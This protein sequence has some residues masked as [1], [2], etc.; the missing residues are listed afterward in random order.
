MQLAPGAPCQG[1]GSS[2]RGGRRSL[3][4]RASP[5]LPETQSRPTR[6]CAGTCSASFPVVCPPRGAGGRAALTHCSGTGA[7]SC[8]LLVHTA[9]GHPSCP[10]T[11]PGS[12][13]RRSNAQQQAL[14]SYRAEGGDLRDDSSP[15]CQTHVFRRTRKCRGF[16]NPSALPGLTDNAGLRQEKNNPGFTRVTAGICRQ[17]SSKAG[18]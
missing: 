5:S 10:R 12:G 17:A 7:G 8:H 6:F 2:R 3:K 15:P 13:Q 1:A 16:P 11:M 18:F 4:L 14:L 9:L